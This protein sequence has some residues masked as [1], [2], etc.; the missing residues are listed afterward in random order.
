MDNLTEQTPSLNPW[1]TIWTRPRATIRQI[2]DSDPKRLVLILAMGGGIAGT[3]ERSAKKSLGDQV[4]S[5]YLP[6]VILMG[7]ALV[8]VL[9]LYLFGLIFRWTGRWL[10]G[11]ADSVQVRAA[12]A[13]SSVPII[14]ALPLWI[15]LI[16]LAGENLF[17]S[18][19]PSR[20]LGPPQAI[21][22]TALGGI[23]T[24]VY[25]W[26][27]FTAVKTLA[28]VHQFSAWKALATSSE[29]I[30]NSLMSS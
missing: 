25:I 6:G 18:G 12:L 28:E 1:L 10:G 13:W 24:V 11:K 22:T 26:S 21:A 4:P 9:S 14:L 8:G 30:I 3:L 5:Q 17:K 19:Q 27:Y 2:V 15:P 7:G 20:G 23:L 29:S 16:A